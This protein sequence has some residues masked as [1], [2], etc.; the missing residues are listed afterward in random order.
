MAIIVLPPSFLHCGFKSHHEPLSL[1]HCFSAFSMQCWRRCLLDGALMWN[2]LFFQ[3]QQ[4]MPKRQWNSPSN[5]ITILF[6]STRDWAKET[7]VCP[8][9]AGT[10]RDGH[11]DDDVVPTVFCLFS[12]VL[13]LQWQLL[14]PS[15]L[16][17]VLHSDCKRVVTG[18]ILSSVAAYRSSR[19]LYPDN[20][21]HMYI[22]TTKIDDVLLFKPQLFSST[23]PNLPFFIWVYC[24]ASWR[25][26]QIHA[27]GNVKPGWSFLLIYSSKR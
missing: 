7:A 21:S 15:N 11:S 25:E 20:I 14:L 4:N 6:A 12:S 27:P 8:C 24:L 1:D 26:A 5:L 3:G 2:L 13:L 19:L 18:C 22:K 10:L 16:D 23:L 9:Q 17:W